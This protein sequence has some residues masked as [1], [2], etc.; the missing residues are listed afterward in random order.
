VDLK[1]RI[2]KTA[3]SLFLRLGVKS[4]TMDDIAKELGISKKT[5]Y[6]HFTDKDNIVFEVL[7]FTL[8][9]ERAEAERIA[10]IYENPIEEIFQSMKEM[11][12]MF[13]NIN[14]ILFYDLRKYHPK[15]WELYVN[16][17]NDFLYIVKRNL[18]RGVL[19]GLY[20][21]EIDIDLMARFRVETVDL[22]FDISNFNIKQSNVLKVQ[23]HFI[24]HFIRGILTSQ[25]LEFYET[26]KRKFI[27]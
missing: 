11:N 23:T 17:K 27:K 4:I 8:A 9:R 14:P 16:F 10:G 2:L 18:E 5:I 25:G 22:A 15:A 13:E 3:A 6:I 26:H 12:E 1:E 24:D 7:S 21:K 20:R 19:N